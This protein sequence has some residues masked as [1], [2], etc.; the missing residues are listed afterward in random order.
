[1]VKGEKMNIELRNWEWECGDKCCYDWGTK[2]IIDGNKLLNDTSND[3]DV[4]RA[5]LEYVGITDFSIEVTDE[6]C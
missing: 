2:L 3:E 5:I 1:V 6:D 4:I